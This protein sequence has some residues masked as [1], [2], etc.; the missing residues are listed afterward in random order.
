MTDYKKMYAIVCA[1][2]SEALDQLADTPENAAAKRI[3]QEALFAAEEVYLS[4]ETESEI[5][6][7]ISD[8]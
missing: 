6:N 2:A 1:A 3:L 7:S 5:Q 4:D 8:S